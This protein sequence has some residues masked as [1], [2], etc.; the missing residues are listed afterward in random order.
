MTPETQQRIDNLVKQNKIMVF[1][2]GN[3]L[4]P[5]CGFSNNVVQILNVLGVPFETCDVL[6]DAEIRQGIKEYSN[7]PTI[8]QVY[9]DG[10]FVGGSDIMIELYQ[11]GELQQM[12]EVALAS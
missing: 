5:Q 2:K 11:K 1:M 9:I 7:W 12:V 8:P 10:Q 3:K 4:M 6:E